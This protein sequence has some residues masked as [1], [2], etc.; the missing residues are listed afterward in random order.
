MHSSACSEDMP[1]GPLAPLD[2]ENQR[3]SRFCARDAGL[4]TTDGNRPRCSKRRRRTSHPDWNPDA[5]L[6]ASAAG[7]LPE[8]FQRFSRLKLHYKLPHHAANCRIGWSRFASL[9]CSDFSPARFWLLS[10]C[11]G[12]T[13][14]TRCGVHTRDSWPVLP[15]RLPLPAK[16]MQRYSDEAGW[17]RGSERRL[18]R[19]TNPRPL[20]EEH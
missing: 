4:D 12:E 18:L 14:I 3:T 17:A 9:S 20:R 15:A 19:C 5:A 10:E 7:S 8:L 1:S 6:P 11:C 16:K 13:K 2:A